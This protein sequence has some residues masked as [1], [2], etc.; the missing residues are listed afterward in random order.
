MKVNLY[1]HDND[2]VYNGTDKEEDLKDRFCHLMKDLSDIHQSD[3]T[4]YFSELMASVHVFGEEDLFQF[5]ERML[6]EEEK[7]FF[8]ALWDEDAQYYSLDKIEL[9]KLTHYTPD[10][11]ECNACVVLN[12]VEVQEYDCTHYI[13]FDVYKVIYNRHSWNTLQRQILGNHPGDA[14]LFVIGCRKCF[15][16]LE[17]GVECRKNMERSVS[18][19]SRKI[20]YYLSC[21]N[22]CFLD[23]LN[24]HP[25]KSSANEVLA[26]FAGRYG[27]DK[28]GSLQRN[29]QDKGKYT[30]E[31]SGNKKYVCDAHFKIQHSDA[32]GKEKEIARIYIYYGNAGKP[33]KKIWVGSMGGYHA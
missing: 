22:D 1:L 4:L 10:E 5:A 13:T 29:T 3:V 20:V 6:P 7:G 28:A 11:K 21:V 9:E 23:F 25:N 14:D 33:E 26:D 16:N 18:T 30:F 2:F 32:G 27:M 15:E 31:F 19:C 8:Y 12:E 17:F 24:T